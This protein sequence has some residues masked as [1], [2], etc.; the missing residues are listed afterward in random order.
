MTTQS[1]NEKNSLTVCQ[2]AQEVTLVTQQFFQ[3][4][5]FFSTVILHFFL[6]KEHICQTPEPSH[7]RHIQSPKQKADSKTSFPTS[8]AAFLSGLPGGFL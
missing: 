6:S 2:E 4:P 1:K 3:G 8:G 5:H 7:K